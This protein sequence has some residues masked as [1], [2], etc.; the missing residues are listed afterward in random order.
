VNRE[1]LEELRG[2]ATQLMAGVVGLLA[3][4]ETAAPRLLTPEQACE[5]LGVSRSTLQELIDSGALPV[6][7]VTGRAVRVD[8]R[9]VEAFVKARRVRRG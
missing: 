3:E 2:L 4:P 6:V 9:D 5:A 1:T 7:E 8:V